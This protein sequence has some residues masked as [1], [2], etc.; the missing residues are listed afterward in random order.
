ME[1]GTSSFNR[2]RAVTFLLRVFSQLTAPEAYARV[3]SIAPGGE[4]AG[5]GIF[6]GAYGSLVFSHYDHG[7]KDCPMYTREELF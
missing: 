5:R 2:D 7:S 4:W 3:D 6:A 1:T